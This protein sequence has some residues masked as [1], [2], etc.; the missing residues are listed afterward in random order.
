M[1][2]NH[3]MLD[4]ETL[5]ANPGCVVLS[6]GIASFK[7]DG[8]GENWSAFHALNLPEQIKRGFTIEAN[9]LQWWMK[10]SADAASVSFSDTS[11]SVSMMS[12]LMSLS[13][14]IRQLD[15]Q[16]LFAR[17]Y[18]FDFGILGHLFDEYGIGRPWKYNQ[19]RCVRT[20]TSMV[21]ADALAEHLASK[22][23]GVVDSDDGD[24]DTEVL[25]FVAHSPV[26]DCIKQ[27]VEVQ[28]AC[29]ILGIPDFE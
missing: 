15:P 26:D 11:N 12:L 10:Q 7:I 23:I 8:D 5:G 29:R 27:I 22:G 28:G 17:G 21:Q 24:G 14:Q 2:K 25:T 6:V 18:D 4:I 3:L 9:T 19:L 1:S 13:Q 16:Y 20:V